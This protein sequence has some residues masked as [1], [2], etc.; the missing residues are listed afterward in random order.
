M[1][2]IQKLLLKLPAPAKAEMALRAIGLSAEEM[3]AMD[4]LVASLRSNDLISAI[5]PESIT[6]TKS[7]LSSMFMSKGI[8]GP[9]GETKIGALQFVHNVPVTRMASKFLAT[10][11]EKQSDQVPARLIMSA[12]GKLIDMSGQTVPR[13]FDSLS[14]MF[15]LGL[16]PALRELSPAPAL[17]RD[18]GSVDNATPLIVKCRHC[19][20]FNMY[21]ETSSGSHE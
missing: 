19:N 16:F 21:E 8:T 10:Y 1:N 20:Q 13:E 18:N 6:D 7:L 5:V 12:T 17:P 11:V 3:S 15:E 2:A 14:D 9:D 4:A